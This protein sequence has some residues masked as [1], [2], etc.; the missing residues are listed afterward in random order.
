M[1]LRKKEEQ[2]VENHLRYEVIPKEVIS[3]KQNVKD[4]EKRIQIEFKKRI[5]RNSKGNQNKIS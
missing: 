2:S 1:E 3:V 4:V 5:Q